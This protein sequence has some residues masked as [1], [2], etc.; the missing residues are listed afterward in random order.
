VNQPT[1]P[2]KKIEF[3]HPTAY[4]QQGWLNRIVQQ[5]GE[6]AGS[7]VVCV[8]VFDSTSGFIQDRADWNRKQTK[9]RLFPSSS[10]AAFPWTM[11]P[12]AGSGTG[13]IQNTNSL[14]ADAQPEQEMYNQA[15]IKSIFQTGFDYEQK[16][17]ILITFAWNK[18]KVGSLAAINSKLRTCSDWIVTTI[19]QI[20]DQK[21]LKNEVRHYKDLFNFAP[22]AIW[23]EDFS[24]ARQKLFQLPCQNSAELKQYL[25]DNPD[26][27]GEILALIKVVDVN[28]TTIQ[29]WNHRSKEKIIG[30]LK[31]TRP[32]ENF[33]KWVEELVAIYENQYHHVIENQK[34]SAATGNLVHANLYWNVLPTHED[35][36]SR[37]LVSAVDI[38]RQILVEESLKLSEERLRM[39][40][41]SAD[42]V[43][44]VQDLD[45][46]Y[47]YYNG[48]A[49]YGLSSEDV[50]GNTPMELHESFASVQIEKAFSN[51]IS[52]KKPY[53]YEIE[54]AWGNETNWFSNLVYPI[55]STNGEI[56]SVGTIARNITKRKQTEFALVE[57]QKKLSSRV[58][59]LERRN[60]EV[61]LLS[62]ML[63]ALQFCAEVNDAFRII[64]QFL[65]QL[66]SGQSGILFEVQENTES[67][68]PRVSWGIDPNKN[69]S[70]T[71]ADFSVPPEVGRSSTFE[72][73]HTSHGIHLGD[74]TTSRF[75]CQPYL[76]DGVI[77]GCL[78]IQ[79]S[80]EKIDSQDDVLRLAQAASEQI[81]LALANIRLRINLR[82]Q[83]IHDAL[84]GLYNRHYLEEAL[85]RELY[86]QERNGQ[87]LSIIM[88]D[89]DHLKKI[90]DFY[91]HAAGDAVLRELGKLIRRSIRVSDMP[92]RY[93]GDE[94]VL[95]MPETSIETALHRAQVISSHF[96]HLNIPYGTQTLGDFSISAGIACTS[97]HGHTAQDLMNAADHAL[98]KAK[99]AG[100]D[101]IILA[102][103]NQST[104]NQPTIPEEVS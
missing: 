58:Q 104:E 18:Q 24:Q 92:C 66:F 47:T 13:E 101:R 69:I 4:D 64:K 25:A 39:I 21:H 42:D 2:E 68:V 3:V 30:S 38:T 20:L 43:I 89:L 44:L 29:L 76:I 91:G 65:V 36:W 100:R 41:E 11:S 12:S 31:T 45:G 33:D 5:A 10:L 55:F 63:S 70:F 79:A 73:S 46:K 60:Q 85:S 15:S 22:I 87:P 97:I 8:L 103:P 40:L 84:T 7:D 83:A 98:Y 48:L 52:T 34:V 49:K 6:L 80:G 77:S 37:V 90:N 32:E 96:R 57:V 94:F 50:V 86:R 1:Q 56:I 54:K 74:L 61:R 26:L 27:V 16:T 62:E 93:G 9:K 99:Q 51:V 82:Q 14:P 95:V 81:G 53:F 35:D 88:M 102:E 72:I 71:L 17:R 19:H 67:L 59:E 23:E 78:Y 28:E 75:L